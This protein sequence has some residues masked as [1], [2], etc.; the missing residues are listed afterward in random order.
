MSSWRISDPLYV[1]HTHECTIKCTTPPDVHKHSPSHFPTHAHTHT[2]TLVHTH[3]RIHEYMYK[4]TCV[5]IRGPHA[6]THLELNICTWDAKCQFTQCASMH[7]NHPYPN[8]M[9]RI[10]LSSRKVGWQHH[11]WISW[12]AFSFGWIITLSFACKAG[13]K[14]IRFYSVGHKG[15]NIWC[16]SPRQHLFSI[17]PLCFFKCGLKW[18]IWEDE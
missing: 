10:S 4:H 17:S 14:S 13:C 11:S 12:G 15:I 1:Y 8:V 6:F 2:H 3:T 18:S 5:Y 7:S 9:Q 16:Y